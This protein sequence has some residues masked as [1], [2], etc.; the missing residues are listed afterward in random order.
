MRRL[1]LWKQRKSQLN[2]N[3]KDIYASILEIEGLDAQFLESP[4]LRKKFRR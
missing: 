1:M 3:L 4:Q 2:R